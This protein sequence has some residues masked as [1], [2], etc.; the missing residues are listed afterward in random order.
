M[1]T[2]NQQQ[3]DDLDINDEIEQD[4][5]Q[6]MHDEEEHDPV[7]AKAL[8]QGWRPEDEWD[9]DPADWV[10]AKE[11]VFRGQL[12]ERISQEN[13]T[14][15]KLQ[16]ELE[17]VKKALKELGEHNKKLAKIEYDRAL[18][19]LKQEKL[20]ALEEGDHSTVLEIDE[21][22]DSLKETQDDYDYGVDDQEE[23]DTRPQYTDED[24]KL[25]QTWVSRN[26]WFNTDVAMNGAVDALANRYLA[27]HPEDVE[28]MLKYVDVE[29]RK[30]FPHKFKK[31]AT[32]Q[33]VTE[34]NG[35]GQS[36]KKTVTKKFSEKDLNDEQRTVAKT[37]VKQG[38]F[39]SVQEYIDQLVELGELPAQQGE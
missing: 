37:F 20:N 6:D 12:M 38:V 9:G 18:K 3:K 11:F 17:G 23:E 39:D 28:G 7:V 31:R 26:P 1:G 36:K 15:K 16:S 4:I 27:K 2:E 32:G 5:E 35:R 25:L 14:N 10:D 8:E 33:S 19:K 13:K 34:V 22:I 21:Q 24:V 29:I 30:E